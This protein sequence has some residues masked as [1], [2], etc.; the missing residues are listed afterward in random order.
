MKAVT[1][2]VARSSGTPR[3]PHNWIGRQLLHGGR[4]RSCWSTKPCARSGGRPNMPDIISS[5]RAAIV[6]IVA[7]G[8]V[9]APF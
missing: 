2:A 6:S 4:G 8:R 3:L 5:P 1:V 7:S 9:K